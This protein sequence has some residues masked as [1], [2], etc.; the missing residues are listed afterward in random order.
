MT[1]GAP[2]NTTRT[3]AKKTVEPT[4]SDSDVIETTEDGAEFDLDAWLGK[5]G[6]LAERRLKVA[7]KSFRFTASATGNQIVEYNDAIKEGSLGDA[8]GVLLVDPSEKD[9]LVEAFKQQRQPL[10]G[11]LERQYFAQILNYVISGSLSGDAGK[12]SAS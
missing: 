10:T 11:D 7:G 8:L 12:S 6:L 3:A 1:Q 4:V 9:E 5:R 2:K